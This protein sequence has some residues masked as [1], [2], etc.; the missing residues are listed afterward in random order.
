VTDAFQNQLTAI[1]SRIRT[2]RRARR[3]TQ[4]ALSQRTG[5]AEAFLSRIENGRAAPSVH[6]LRRLA[7]ALGI[8]VGDFLGTR[9][10]TVNRVCPV[11]QSGR[12][13]AELIDVP[14]RHLRR[15]AEHYTPRQIRLLQLGNSLVQSGS[16]HTLAA[17]ET[18]M[19]AMLKLPGTR[20]NRPWLRTLDRRPSSSDSPAT[21]GAGSRAEPEGSA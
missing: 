11:S 6:T 21:R 18:V 16:A 14:G 20:R 19:L 1:G 3:L 9:S 4:R 17:L 5:L 10:A 2:M 12:C 7:D 15:P 8:W 13:I